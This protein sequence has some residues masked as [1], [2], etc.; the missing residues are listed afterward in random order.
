[1]TEKQTIEAWSLEHDSDYSR[2]KVARRF[3]VSES[4]LARMYRLYK[5]PPPHRGAYGTKMTKRFYLWIKQLIAK[6]DVHP[7]YISAKWRAARAAAMQEHHGECYMC[8]HNKTPSRL[9]PATMVHHVKPLKQFP[10]HA[11]DLYITDESGNKVIQLMPLCHDCHAEIES[12]AAEN[13]EKFP[14]KW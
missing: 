8:K 10:Q 6:G 9:T 11:L 2:H 12:K 5:L 13:R 3:Y 4:T 1:M 14:E 7:F